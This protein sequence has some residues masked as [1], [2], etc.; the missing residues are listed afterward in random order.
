[1][2]FGLMMVCAFSLILVNIREVTPIFITYLVIIG[3]L[4]LAYLLVPLFACTLFGKNKMTQLQ[5]LQQ[6]IVAP[7]K[8]NYVGIT[9]GGVFVFLCAFISPELYEFN[10]LTAILFTVLAFVTYV[11]IVTNLAKPENNVMKCYFNSLLL[12]KL[13]KISKEADNG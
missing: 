9:A 7:L 13:Q 2:V 5:G 12:G 4:L 1:M 8:D 3:T 6:F 10:I 11:F